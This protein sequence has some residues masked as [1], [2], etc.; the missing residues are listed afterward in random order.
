MSETL[1]Q[2]IERDSNAVKCK[3]GGYAASVEPTDAEVK[4]HGCGRHR[5]CCAR[6]FVC[7]ICGTRY[8]GA[9]PAPEYRD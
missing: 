7:C 4:E 5:S 8:V 2:E 9:A 6:A 1:P 3:C